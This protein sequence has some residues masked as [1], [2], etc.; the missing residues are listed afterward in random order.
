MQD[1]TPTT[2]GPSG[3]IRCAE[4]GSIIR[5]GQ[6][7]VATDGGVFCRICYDNLAIRLRQAVEAQSADVPYSRAALG[8][9]LG[10]VAGSFVWWGFTVLTHIALGLVAVII[11]ILV[12]KGIVIFSGG[13]RSG[14]LQALSVTIAALSYAYASYLVDR[15]FIQQAL[16]DQGNPVTLPFLPLPRSSSTC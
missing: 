7:R 2:A 6:D 4:C 14:R 13:K 10:G 5:E 15:S 1:A 12:G 8:G 11:G 9:I 3:E 16:A